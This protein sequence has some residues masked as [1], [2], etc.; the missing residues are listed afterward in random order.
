[1][2]QVKDIDGKVID[3]QRKELFKLYRSVAEQTLNLEKP[4]YRIVIFA[5]YSDSEYFIIELGK[6]NIKLWQKIL[7]F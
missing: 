4:A 2:P 5:G 1:M 7:I 3:N 6:K